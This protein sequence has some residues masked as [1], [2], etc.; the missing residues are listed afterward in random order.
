MGGPGFFKR[1]EET[2]RQE[3]FYSKAERDARYFWLQRLGCVARRWVL[4]KQLTDRG[5]VDIYMLNI[6]TLSEAV[7]DLRGE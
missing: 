4:K 2:M 5:V 6:L 1:R 3:T 7:D